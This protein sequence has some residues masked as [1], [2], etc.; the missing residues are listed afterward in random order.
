MSLDVGTYNRADLE[1]LGIVNDDASSVQVSEGFQITLY[2][3]N[4]QLGAGVR[5]TQDTSCLTNYSL[6]DGVSS[7]VVSR[8]QEPEL[9]GSEIACLY[10][11]THFNGGKICLSPGAYNL[12]SDWVDEASAAIVADGYQLTLYADAD[13][14]GK[15]GVITGIAGTLSS[16]DMNNQANSYRLVRAENTCFDSSACD[17]TPDVTAVS[18]N[19]KEG[20]A[21]RKGYTAEIGITLNNASDQSGWVK[22]TPFL[23]SKR[24]TD[25]NDVELASVYAEVGASGNTTVSIDLPAFITDPTTHKRYAVGHGDYD[26]SK[27]VMV[28]ANNNATTDSDYNGKTFNVE[29]TNAVLPIVVYDPEYFSKANYTNTPANYIKEV[30]TRPAELFNEQEDSYTYYA[31][32]F[33]EMMDVRHESY[34]VPGF[35]IDP[36][37]GGT[38]EQA[39]AYVEQAIGLAAGVWGGTGVTTDVDHHGFDYAIALSDDQGGGVACGW[40]DVQVS[41]YIG[42]DLDRLQIIAVH[43]SGHLFGAPHCDPKQGYVMCS[44]EKHQRYIDDGVFVWHQDSRN[45]LQDRFD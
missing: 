13:Q 15:E 26:I 36:N 17:L 3:H 44:G 4:N 12:P 42:T 29:K 5:L 37:A 28:N 2:R 35:A 11:L 10:D 25:Y 18:V 1:T 9:E 20:G 21:P 7:I 32:G 8:V 24:F 22:V 33:D 40:I 23:T 30:F 19:H 43:E 41:G 14:T 39:T 27:V 34:P 31:G 6:N 38:C 16:A 45:V